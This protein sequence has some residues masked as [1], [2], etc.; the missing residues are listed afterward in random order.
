MSFVNIVGVTYGRLKYTK[1]WLEAIYSTEN[2]TPFKVTVVNNAH[3]SEN[4]EC[5]EWLKEQFFSDRIDNL[6]L[7]RKNVGVAKAANA[8]W[9]KESKADF[10]LKLD[11]DMIAKKDGWLDDLV[12]AYSNKIRGIG[13]LGYNVEPVSFPINFRTDNEYDL[14]IKHGNLGGA[15]L[16]IPKETEN[17]IGH[18]CEAYQT[19]GEED[20]DYNIRLSLAGMWNAYM[21]DEDAFYHLPAGKA[22]VI[23][24]TQAGFKASDGLE[25]INETEYRSFK[26]SFREINVPKLM[27]RIQGYQSKEIPLK[28]ISK[29]DKDFR[30][31]WVK[32]KR[33]N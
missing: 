3:P 14:R 8:G 16:F 29:A 28:F 19:Y 31:L 21:E 5:E 20:A 13:T 24:T 1:Q 32:K 7:L 27:K 9:L 26:D 33:K 22:A 4:Y 12:N 11:N 30:F 23:D 17:K 25:E 15:C 6:A 10:F 2:S 18:F